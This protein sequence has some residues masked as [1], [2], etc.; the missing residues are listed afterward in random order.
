MAI[1]VIELTRSYPKLTMLA[2]RV[3]AAVTGRPYFFNRQRMRLRAF[4]EIN[5]RIPFENYIETGTYLGSTTHFLATTA[6]RRGAPVYS[7]EINDDHYEIASRTVGDMENVHLHHGNSVD[8]LR[9]LSTTVSDAVNFVYLDAHWYDYLP[10]RDELSVIGDWP[11][12]V[13][14]IDD[15]KVP[16]DE[17]FGWDR[18]D[19][20]RE[21]CMAYIEGSIGAGAVY[22]PN[23]SAEQEGLKIARGYC[24]IAFSERY[25]EV[26]DGV[27]LL[28]R[29]G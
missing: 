11:N 27:R 26:L 22:F 8:F 28:R 1:D 6:R 19:D 12:T 7:C 23:Y 10:L 13:V 16:F 9:S 15:F 25:A 2:R 17:R 5:A 14:M 20:E 24:V 3:R 18:Y 4:R 21:I 29:F